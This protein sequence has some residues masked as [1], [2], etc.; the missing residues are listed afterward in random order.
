V[1]FTPI[2]GLGAHPE[3]FNDGEKTAAG[4]SKTSM[5]IY[6][7][8]SFKTQKIIHSIIPIRVA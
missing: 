8:R 6:L 5:N 7:T 3:G 4:S 2:P 1:V